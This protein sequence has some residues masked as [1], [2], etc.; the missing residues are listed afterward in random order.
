MN[1]QADIKWIQN[2]LAQVK[3]PMLIDAF[4]NLLQYRRKKTIVTDID[5][6]N[7]AIDRSLEDI[8]NGNVYTHEQMGM[9]IKQWAKGK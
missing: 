3:D 6:Y 8:A 9:R 1:L 5:D 4:K 7:A 2:E